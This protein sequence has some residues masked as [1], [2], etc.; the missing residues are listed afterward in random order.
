MVKGRPRRQRNPPVAV[1]TVTVGLEGDPASRGRYWLWQVAAL[2][3]NSSEPNLG[4]TLPYN[5][6]VRDSTTDDVIYREGPMQA[7]IATQICDEFVAAIE[8]HGVSK[9]V[10][11]KDH[12]WRTEP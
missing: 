9:F 1:S 8:H 10:Y 4:R 6:V 2:A 3:L 11:R 5:V 7:W 12:G